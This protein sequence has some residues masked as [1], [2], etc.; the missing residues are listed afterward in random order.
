MCLFH[1]KSEVIRMPRYIVTEVATQQISVLTG[2]DDRI[3]YAIIR[4]QFH[5]HC[6]HLKGNIIYMYKKKQWIHC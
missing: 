4:K 3:H 6:G 1:I 2:I 5:I